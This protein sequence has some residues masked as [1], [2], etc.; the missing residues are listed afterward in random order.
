MREDAN[1]RE[2]MIISP[3]YDAKANVLAETRKGEHQPYGDPTLSD[4][5]GLLSHALARCKLRVKGSLRSC[6]RNIVFILIF[7]T[8]SCIVPKSGKRMLNTVGIEEQLL[9]KLSL[10]FHGW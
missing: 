5:A 2:E 4:S 9:E 7:S 6:N 10:P 8:F 3:T 1:F